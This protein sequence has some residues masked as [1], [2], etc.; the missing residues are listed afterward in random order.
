MAQCEA[1]R[2]GFAQVILPLPSLL[3]PPSQGSIIQSQS[4][5]ASCGLILMR[6][7]NTQATRSKSP[8]RLEGC[9]G[10]YLS[11]TKIYFQ[12]PS[13]F[14]LSGRI[15]LSIGG[16]KNLRGQS[17]HY[18]NQAQSTLVRFICRSLQ[19]APPDGA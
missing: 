10:G 19:W 11:R 6:R 13:G 2:R 3:L 15:L 16:A 17:P 14:L 4:V 1:Q 7:S 8:G 5:R 18:A 9:S 12:R